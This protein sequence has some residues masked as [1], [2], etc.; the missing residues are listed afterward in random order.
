MFYGF[1]TAGSNA[2]GQI[3][4]TK[5]RDVS[6][7][8]DLLEA[9]IG[10]LSMISQALWEFIKQNHPE[11][12]EQHLAD[13]VMEIDLSDGTLDGKVKKKVRHCGSCKRAL[14]PRHMRCIYCGSVNLKVF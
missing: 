4:G 9:E 10:R 7:K 6:T 12:T 13:K 1:N 3:S 2:G 14:N 11:F 8:Q 5:T